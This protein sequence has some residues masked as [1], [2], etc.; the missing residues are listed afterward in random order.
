M[1]NARPGTGFYRREMG[2]RDALGILPWPVTLLVIARALPTETSIYVGSLR[3]SPYRILLIFTLVPSLLR[4]FSRRV[5]APHIIDYLMI[6]HCAWVFL[7][8]MVNEGV[9]KGI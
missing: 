3:L 8:F 5:G 9:G 6:G 4:L 1:S 7:A 2:F